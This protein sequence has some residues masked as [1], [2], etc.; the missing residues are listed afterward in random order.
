MGSFVFFRCQKPE[1][2]NAKMQSSKGNERE[3]DDTQVVPYKA[4]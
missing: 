2:L 1:K 4:L 3:R